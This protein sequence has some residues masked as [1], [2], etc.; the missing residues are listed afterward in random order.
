MADILLVAASGLARE[1][2]ASVRDAGTDRV[3][4]ILDDDPALAGTTVSGVPVLG[5]A[6]LAAQRSERLLLCPGQGAARIALAARLADLGVGAERYAVHVH[7]S[8]VIGAG[9]A[10]GAGSILLA[11][12][13][14]TCD[15]TVGEHVVLMPRTVLTHDDE[16]ADGV[17]C[18]AGVTLAG[19]VRVGERAYLGM[20]TSVRQDVRVGADATLGMGAVVLRDVPPGR[21]WVGA[22]AAE[23]RRDRAGGPALPHPRPVGVLPLLTSHGRIRVP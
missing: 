23:L 15:V 13:V 17:T 16:L 7:P 4:G 14:L 1:T 22:P 2:L 3:V 5:P 6:A 10:V 11:G 12:C 9:S 19:R 8:V 20:Q 21:T 18:A